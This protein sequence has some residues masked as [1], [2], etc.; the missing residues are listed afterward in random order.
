MS[1]T[2]LPHVSTY[3]RDVVSR[4]GRLLLTRREH[5]KVR[6]VPRAGSRHGR[7]ALAGLLPPASPHGTRGHERCHGRLVTEP[8]PAYPAVADVDY[9]S[10]A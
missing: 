5:L 6:P 10:A 2:H 7:P 3:S 8:C 4:A 9:Q 1:D